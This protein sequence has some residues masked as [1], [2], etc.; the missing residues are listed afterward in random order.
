MPI[1]KRN[2]KQPVGPL[3]RR[4][5]VTSWDA[6]F[7]VGVLIE[8]RV[9]ERWGSTALT[10]RGDLDEP[11]RDT[12]KCEV[13]ILQSAATSLTIHRPP[14]IGSVRRTKP[15][16]DVLMALSPAEFASVLALASSGLLAYC[17]LSLMPPR[18]GS[19]PLTWISFDTASP[20]A[21]DEEST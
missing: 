16:L 2:R 7:S 12:S 6:H 21:D 15:I 5:T 10:V 14:G 11:V 8:K 13:T 17:S 18:Y 1:T 4:L 20:D 9:P 19:G 3:H